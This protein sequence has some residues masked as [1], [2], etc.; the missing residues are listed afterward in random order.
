MKMLST[1]ERT[2]T[3]WAKELEKDGLVK[4]RSQ[5]FGGKDLELTKNALEKAKIEEEEEKVRR[6]R[7]ELEKIREEQKMMIKDSY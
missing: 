3:K 2:V 4:I 5:I 1:D 7:E 6:I